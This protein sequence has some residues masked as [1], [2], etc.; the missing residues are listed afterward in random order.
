MKSVKRDYDLHLG[1]YNNDEYCGGIWGRVMTS[2][3][4]RHGER[5]LAY[6][7]FN[8]ATHIVQK[9][10]S[11]PRYSDIDVE[12]IKVTFRPGDEQRFDLVFYPPRM[13]EAERREKK[14]GG[15]RLL[16]IRGKEVPVAWKEFVPAEPVSEI[17]PS[18]VPF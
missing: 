18:E 17:E 1:I 16:V 3:I 8:K 10:L 4:Y 7:A 14:I 6:Y 11:D 15:I 5:N 9:W 12:D 2:D 13:T